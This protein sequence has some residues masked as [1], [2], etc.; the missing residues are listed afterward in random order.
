LAVTGTPEIHSGAR[1]PAEVPPH[2]LG[3]AEVGDL[4]HQRAV[5]QDV[6]RLDVA[7]D[8]AV[9]AALVQVQQPP[10][11]ADRDLVPR[12]PAQHGGGGGFSEEGLVQ[13]AVGHVVVDEQPLA[14]AAG[15]EAA[16]ADEVD[17][18]DRADGAHLVPEL[19]VAHGDGF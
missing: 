12:A 10:R 4:R 18:V 15:A 11:R 17:V 8:D 14:A 1:Y 5:E 13:R 6:L 16:E 7:V 19:L 9:A 3:E 2:Q